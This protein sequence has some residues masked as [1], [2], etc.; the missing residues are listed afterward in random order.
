MEDAFE[1]GRA[2]WP[3]LPV[4]AADYIA[5]VG[6]AEGDLVF[7]DLYLACACHHGVPGA[8]EAFE[9]L[10]VPSIEGALARMN[11]GKTVTDEVKQIVLDQLFVGGKIAT[12]SGRGN[13]K[14]WVRII[15]VREASRIL[16][17][18]NKT[19][20][21]D[22]AMFD[23]LAPTDRED[24]ELEYLKAHYRGQFR[25]AFLATVAELPRR[26]RTALR[27]NVLDGRSIDEIGATFRVNRSTAH[28]WLTQAREILITG[29]KKRLMSELAISP[30]E[31]E[32]VIRLVRSSLDVSLENV[33][34]TKT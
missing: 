11:A 18:G 33:L 17:A 25:T 21:A 24:P 29:T 20:S 6:D 5:F 15:A 2:A 16:R 19:V 9:A 12:Y 13:L 7:T 23:A 4:S 30:A 3:D 28:R 34:R 32:S 14:G 26:E 27:M 31:V 8:V 10:C 22:D 1:A